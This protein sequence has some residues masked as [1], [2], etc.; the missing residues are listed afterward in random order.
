MVL[1]FCVTIIKVQERCFLHFF[2]QNVRYSTR[3]A[4]L[5]FRILAYFTK[6]A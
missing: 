4:F 6:N 1:M 2:L 5:F 3:F